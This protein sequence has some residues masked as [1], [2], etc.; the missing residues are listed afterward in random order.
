M[1]VLSQQ[2]NSILIYLSSCGQAVCVCIDYIMPSPSSS[3][4]S[5]LESQPAHANSLSFPSMEELARRS[6]S[7]LLDYSVSYYT[8]ITQ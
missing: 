4:A 1:F 2:F 5:G 6:T 8:G 7:L 3:L